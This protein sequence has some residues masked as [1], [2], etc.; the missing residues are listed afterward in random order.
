MRAA[1]KTI[2]ARDGD[3]PRA[4]RGDKQP[5]GASIAISFRLISPLAFRMPSTAVR[6]R[7]SFVQQRG[8]TLYNTL[9]TRR[10]RLRLHVAND[11]WQDARPSSKSRRRPAQ[12]AA[13]RPRSGIICHRARFARWRVLF[14]KTAETPPR[15]PPLAQ[16]LFRVFTIIERRR[17]RSGS[18]GESK[19]SSGDEE[20]ADSSR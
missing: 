14:I 11:K 13:G 9:V 17:Y 1:L 6:A 3:G 15:Y 10:L 2:Q 7:G 12:R 5:N 8:Y 18:E 16:L 19:R 4:E 20:R